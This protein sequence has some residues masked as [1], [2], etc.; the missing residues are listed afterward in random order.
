V[1]PTGWAAELAGEVADV[2]GRAA[3]RVVE[4]E[5]ARGSKAVGERGVSIR[6]SR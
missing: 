3:D 4:D 2:G 5:D 6:W 1:D